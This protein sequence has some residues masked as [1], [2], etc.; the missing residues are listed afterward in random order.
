MNIPTNPPFNPLQFIPPSTKQTTL[1]QPISH[2]LITAHEPLPRGGNHCTIYIPTT[3]STSTPSSNTT[4]ISSIQLDMT[5]SYTTPATTKPTNPAGAGSKGILILS[6]LP[7]TLPPRATKSFRIDIRP[8]YKIADLVDLLVSEG[9]HKYEFNAEGEGCRFWVD[10]VVELFEEKGWVVD[11]D[12]EGG[13]KGDGSGQVGSVWLIDWG[14]SGIYPEGFDYVGIKK[15]RSFGPE[16]VDMLLEVIP[17]YEELF[18]HMRYIV[19]GLTTGRYLQEN[20]V[21]NI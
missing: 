1:S 6:A 7:Y 3:P 16:F 11:G 12:A 14:Y 21:A 4:P 8:G 17:N 20:K 19:F 10:G 5:P 2:L 13:R 9:R 15:K 18:Q